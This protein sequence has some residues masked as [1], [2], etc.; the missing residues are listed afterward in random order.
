MG[1]FN[2]RIKDRQLNE[3]IEEAQADP[4][5]DSPAMGEIVQRFDG[6]AKKEARRLTADTHLQDDLANC[7]RIELVNAVR[8]HD[9]TRPGFPAY[10]RICMRGAAAR[11]LSRTRSWGRGNANVK[12]SVTDFTAAESEPLIPR[13]L[14]DVETSTWGDGPTAAAVEALSPAHRDLLEQRYAEDWTLAQIGEATNTTIS[15][16]RQ[17]LETAQRNVTAH[18]AA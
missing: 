4:R 5:N 6:L 2:C 18:L 10:A 8:R 7:A 12:V 15:A 13:I 1:L 3:L 11:A 14:V 17:R 9:C 16:V